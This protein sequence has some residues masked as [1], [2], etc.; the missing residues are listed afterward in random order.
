VGIVSVLALILLEVMNING[1]GDETAF[2]LSSQM[3]GE[4][5]I[6]LLFFISIL[7]GAAGVLDDVTI[8]QVSSMY[9]IYKANPKLTTKQL[10]SRKRTC[11]FY[12]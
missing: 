12:D 8:G 5:N 10:Y 9:E 6:K 3:N 2:L 4:I 7:I 1:L 11:I